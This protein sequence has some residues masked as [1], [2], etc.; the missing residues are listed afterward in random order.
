MFLYALIKK[1]PFFGQW[2]RVEIASKHLTQLYLSFYFA[3]GYLTL[4]ENT[5]VYHH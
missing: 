4:A 2:G 3:H 1:S 5:L